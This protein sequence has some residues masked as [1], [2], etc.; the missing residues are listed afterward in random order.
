MIETW[1]ETPIYFNQILGSALDKIQKE[2]EPV[3]LN[4]KNNQ[5]FVSREDW[6]THLLSDPTF[7]KNIIT[8]YSLTNLQKEIEKNINFY[9]DN[10]GFL[11]KREF[12]IT[13]SWMIC[14][15][16][17]H[18]A[19]VHNHGYSDISGCYYFLTNMQDGDI[20][21]E[22]PNKHVATNYCFDHLIS[23]VKYSP[24]IG[25]ILLFPSWLEHG[26]H[27][28]ACD[29]ERVSISFNVYFDKY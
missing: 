9:L 21:F 27:T 26:V 29:S 8:E 25:K 18:Y 3:Y 20:F 28:N 5:G 4:F 24:E 7:S 1:F 13:S 12:R 11:K 22:S 19:H 23:R 15:K 17:G 10:I 16:K 6:R 2:I 14:C